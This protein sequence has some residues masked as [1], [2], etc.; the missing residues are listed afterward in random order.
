ML[1]K[2][3]PEWTKM[4]CNIGMSWMVYVVKVHFKNVENKGFLKITS[5]ITM[6]I[7]S[8]FFKDLH[9]FCIYNTTHNKSIIKVI[10]VSWQVKS[11]KLGIFL[12]QATIFGNKCCEKKHYSKQICL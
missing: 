9:Y 7:L 12:L 3:M 1:D 10:C 2:V 4:T 5:R 11:P 8:S 6:F